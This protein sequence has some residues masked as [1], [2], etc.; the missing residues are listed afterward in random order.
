[1]PVA[2]AHPG[3][4][5]STPGLPLLFLIFG[6][7]ARVFNPTSTRTDFPSLPQL[8]YPV[9][10]YCYCLTPLP[11]L[12]PRI[13]PYCN[14]WYPSLVA[15]SWRAISIT[16]FFIRSTLPNANCHLLSHTQTYALTYLSV[17]FFTSC[18]SYHHAR[19]TSITNSDQLL[20]LPL[21][22]PT[23]APIHNKR[24]MPS[25]FAQRYHPRQRN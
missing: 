7:V 13:S 21:D 9:C 20:H 22:V 12:D 18:D 24:P 10:V 23:A 2:S 15:D 3:Y 14:F 8:I 17:L 19:P 25:S 4:P 6:L 5:L 11:S 1:M 16:A